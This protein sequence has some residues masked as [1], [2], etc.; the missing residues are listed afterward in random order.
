MRCSG[1]RGGGETA[2]TPVS[3]RGGGKREKEG[4]GVWYRNTD[5]EI[6]VRLGDP[7][8][9]YIEVGGVPGIFRDRLDEDGEL[10][11]CSPLSP[12]EGSSFPAKWVALRKWRNRS[13]VWG[14]DGNWEEASAKWELCKRDVFGGVVI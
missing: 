12:P 4:W 13:V 1:K 5:E 10:F 8:E 6:D 11:F 3:C 9:W 7:I 2:A 14:G